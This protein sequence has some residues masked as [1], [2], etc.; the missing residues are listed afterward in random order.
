MIPGVETPEISY[1]YPLITLDRPLDVGGAMRTTRE[2]AILDVVRESTISNK[3]IGAIDLEDGKF[4]TV[5]V[6]EKN[7]D[8]FNFVALVDVDKEGSST[9]SL[10]QNAQE[11]TDLDL[12]IRMCSGEQLRRVGIFFDKQTNTFF[13]YIKTKP[14]MYNSPKESRRKNRFSADPTTAGALLAAKPEDV[15]YA[16]NLTPADFKHR[17]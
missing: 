7:F 10:S 16:Y 9:V 2:P 1:V 4:K 14:E 3:G 13:V 5:E 8:E 17:V 6:T 15:L 11:V 12:F